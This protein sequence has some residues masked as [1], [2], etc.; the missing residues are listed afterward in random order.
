M[1]R[2]SVK[3]KG[4][5][6]IGG[7]WVPPTT[8]ETHAVMNPATG[9]SIEDLEVASGTREDVDRAV[10]AAQK[11]YD[12]VWFDTTPRERS[13]LLFRLADAIEADCDELARLET[14]NVGQPLAGSKSVITDYIVDNLRYFAGAG[15]NLEG[16]SAGEYVR[17]FTS[18]I[19]REPLGV[20]AGIAPWNYPL[21][22]AVWKLGPALAAG[23]TSIIKPARNTPLTTLRLAELAADI[24]PPGVLN[25]VTGRGSE[26]GDALVRHPQ[27]RLVSLTGDTATGRAISAAAAST[28][29]RLH[30]ELGGKAPVIV[31]ADADLDAV[32]ETVRIGGYF[33]SG[34]DCTACC[35]VIASIEI[36]ED[37]VERLAKAVRSIK[38]GDP[39]D[40]E[41][42]MGPVVSA[43]Q[44]DNVAGFVDRAREAGA[45][46]MV[47]GASIDGPGF[48]YEPTVIVNVAQ[49]SEIVQNEV[50]GPVVTVQ[51]FTD[52]H[53]A[54]AMANDCDYGLTASVWTA[55]GPT[56]LRVARRLQYGF[57]GV[58]NHFIGASEMPHGGCKQSGYGKDMS[59]YSLE[60]YTL[61]KHVNL[62]L[63]YHAPFPQDYLGNTL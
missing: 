11:A 5:L 34:Q 2:A 33:N 12:E 14:L 6:F 25:V 13:T 61:I 59:I 16:R 17:G 60:D 57:V 29:K 36:Y 47:G 51:S 43:A 15:R 48:F 30:L 46:V 20:T 18:V 63:D 41:T 37:L 52:E 4:C 7:E 38:V 58:N 23:N 22:M 49:E 40:A 55:D 54:V 1:S 28:V 44:R 42:E 56:G 26:V 10:T 24:L 19:R 3:T 53:E 9:E 50:F 31:F 39:Q 62:A 45:E 35:R 27:V 8:G 21:E 32:V